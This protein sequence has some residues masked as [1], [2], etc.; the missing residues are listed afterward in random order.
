[1]SDTTKVIV[2]NN[3]E[4]GG[5]LSITYPVESSPDSLDDIKKKVVP[6][7]VTSYIVNKSDVPTDRSFR[8]AWTYTE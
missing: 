5:G 3:P 1:M 7:G 6:D 8:D 4:E 2:W